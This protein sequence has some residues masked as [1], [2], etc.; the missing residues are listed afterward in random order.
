[1]QTK[2]VYI[3]SAVRTPIGS[4]GGSLA[5]L[6]ATELGA[7]ALK[8]AL[9]KAGVDGQEVDQVIMGN[10]I[11]ANLGQAPARQAAKK[12]GLPDTVECTTVNK[13]CASGTKAIM[14]AAQAIML[15]QSDVIL[16]GGM[17]SMSNVPYY[18]DKARF[19]AKYGHS[20]MIDGLMKD[21]LWDPYNDYAMG[22]AAEHTAKEMGFTREQQDEF[23]I[24]SYTRSAKAA[25]EGKKKD[26]IVPVTIESR[27]KTTV[28]EDD[29][30]YLKVDFTKVA[31]LR[32]A[33]TKDGTVTAANASTLN[34]GAAAILLMS[35]EKAEELGV[36]PIAKIR[37]FADAEQ[38]PEW[39]TTSPSLAIPKALKN[40]GVDASEVDFYEINEAFSVVS[41]ANNKLLNLEGTKVNV[42]GG[43]VSLGH[44]LG[45]SGARIVTTLLNVLKNEGGKIGVT[46][47][48]NGGGGASSLVVERL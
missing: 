45:A 40:A 39:F 27:G 11:S 34:D 3:I 18:L 47:I 41:L 10:V 31:G 7:I 35:K 13:V 32:P 43:A 25:K 44:P 22:N 48:C 42:Y 38:A 37:G 9:E 33:F 12:A 36:T 1:M 30:E 46:G 2:E 26:E 15:G 14:F 28:I 5:S 24:E 4:F 6:S 21:G 23:A 19:G 16:A 8:G 20:Q 29:E 17:E